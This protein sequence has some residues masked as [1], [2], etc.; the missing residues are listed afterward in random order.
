MTEKLCDCKTLK[1]E[2]LFNTWA[3]WLTD[4]HDFNALDENVKHAWIMAANGKNKPLIKF[5]SQDDEQK[6]EPEPPKKA[7]AKAR[8]TKNDKIIVNIEQ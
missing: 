8:K 7:K 6:E 5:D 3:S 4:E 2:K 1:G